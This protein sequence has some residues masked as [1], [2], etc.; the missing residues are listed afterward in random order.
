MRITHEEV[1]VH[2]IESITKL[3]RTEVEAI[4]Q[5]PT[6]LHRYVLEIE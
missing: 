2:K 6:H 3:L 5:A 1:K 4:C